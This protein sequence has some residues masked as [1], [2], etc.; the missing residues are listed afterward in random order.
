M[1]LLPILA[2]LCYV[3]YKKRKEALDLLISRVNISALSNVNIRVY[4]VKYIFIIIGLAFLILAI[5]RP[6]YG[7]K[8]QEVV[9]E[10]SEIVIAL[11]ISKS[12]L[13]QDSKPNRLEKSKSMIF[14][15]V[16]E[17]AGE[18]IGVIVFSGTAMWQVPMTYDFQALKMFMRGVENIQLPFGGTQISDAINLAVKAVSSNPASSKI[19]I[20]ISDGEDH[21]S[22]IKEA[23][24]NAK[25]ADLKI[26]TVG[27]GTIQGSPIPVRDQN[28]EI[29]GYIKDKS[30]NIVMTKMNPALLKAVAEGTGGRFFDASEKDVSLELV[31]LIK[32]TEKNKFEA[33]EHNAK[34]DRFQIFLFLAL[35]AFFIEL[36]IPVT[37]KAEDGKM[38]S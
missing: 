8:V 9:K 20:L 33:Q 6:Q 1:L 12:M 24:N 37:R 23:I 35:I 28:G 31:R 2:F 19:M 36:M 18:R 13:A 21:D 15:I 22:K 26:F 17:S 11:D 29:T 5:A 3:F 27:V 25:S 32:D 7:D 14:R 16:E 38:R 34:A 30:G 10:S 4:I